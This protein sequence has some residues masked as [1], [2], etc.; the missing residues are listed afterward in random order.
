MI[1]FFM[2]GT[3]LLRLENCTQNDDTRSQ[4]DLVVVLF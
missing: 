1:I 4:N 2:F 3:P